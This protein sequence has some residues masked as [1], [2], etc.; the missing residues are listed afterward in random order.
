MRIKSDDIWPEE[1][2]LLW[3]FGSDICC[4][5]YNSNLRLHATE[6]NTWLEATEIIQSGT[7]MKYNLLACWNSSIGWIILS[8]LL[9][10]KLRN[11]L[12]MPLAQMSTIIYISYSLHT[13]AY[14]LVVT[15][16]SSLRNSWNRQNNSV[17][18]INQFEQGSFM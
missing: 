15:S 16:T 10:V 6:L 8:G 13:F 3:P 14:K 4:Y 7:V 9:I 11:S 1:R 12:S 2:S 5:S 17:H 18:E